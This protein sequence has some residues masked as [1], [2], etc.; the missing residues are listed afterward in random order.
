MVQQFLNRH[1][2]FEI[3]QDDSSVFQG[4]NEAGAREKVGLQILPQ[5][6]HSDGFYIARLLKRES[7]K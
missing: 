4:L 5:D 1:P 2:E 7:S 3:A 6:Y